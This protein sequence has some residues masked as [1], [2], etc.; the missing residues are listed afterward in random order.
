MY[1]TKPQLEV[2]DFVTKCVGQFLKDIMTLPGNIGYNRLITVD[3]E[4]NVMKAVVMLPSIYRFS[5]SMQKGKEVPFLLKAFYTVP[6]CKLEVGIEYLERIQAALHRHDHPHL[7]TT[8]CDVVKLLSVLL[9]GELK[10]QLTNIM[11]HED[12]NWSD[13]KVRADSLSSS[14]LQAG[15]EL[16]VE[17][18]N[19][20]SVKQ[21]MGYQGKPMF[22]TPS[23][24]PP[25]VISPFPVA[26]L[27]SV[28]SM[29]GKAVE[30]KA[31]STKSITTTMDI[32][33]SEPYVALKANAAY[34]IKQKFSC[35]NCKS[36]DP[37]RH[38]Y[39]QCEQLCQ[40]V[41]CGSFPPHW[42]NTCPRLKLLLATKSA[43][44]ASNRRAEKAYAALTPDR[45]ALE[46]QPVLLDTPSELE[47]PYFKGSR[48]PFT[49]DDC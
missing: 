1:V 27:Q 23:L 14:L 2:V 19:T 42:G 40:C 5:V 33:I 12:L 32:P 3:F 30:H 21:P 46:A 29:S 39:Q 49:S 31:V 7:S 44:A 36:D 17:K 25:K 15:L 22:P 10:T 35:A 13:F 38:Y 41:S 26:P 28:T 16:Y 9:P 4:V 8:N 6:P 34:F 37:V 45:T 18:N 43:N 11:L 24:T 20:L 47:Y 48:W